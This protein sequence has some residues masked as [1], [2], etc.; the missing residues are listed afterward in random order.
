MMIDETEQVPGLIDADDQSSNIEFILSVVAEAGTDALTPEE[1]ATYQEY[2]DEQSL[3]EGNEGGHYENLADKISET[4]LS[5]L[6][7][8]VINWVTWDEES[9]QDWEI[10][11]AKGIRMLGVSDKNLTKE[12][13]K[14]CSQVVH[15]L[16]AEAIM[17]FHSRAI[18]EIWPPEGPV[19]TQVLGDLSDEITA[20]AERVQDYLNYLYTTQMPDGFEEVDQML[21]RL[22]LSGSCFKKHFYDPVEESIRSVFVE[23]SDF[24]VPYSATGLRTASR[25]TY[26]VRE[27]HNEVLKKIKI[28]YYRD[29]YVAKDNNESLDYPLVREEIDSS[30]GKTPTSAEDHQRHTMLEMYLDYAFESIDDS[31]DEHEMKGGKVSY[32]YQVIIDRDTSTVMRVQRNWKPDDPKKKKRIYFTHY[33]FMPGLGF[34]GYGLLHL[35]GGLAGAATG[36]LQA[37]M[38]SA[39][40][41]NMQGGFR[42]RDSRIQGGDLA[43]SP[44]EWREVDSSYEELQKAFFK[45]PY[46]EPSA[47][48]F[49]VMQYLDERGQRFVGTTESMVGEANNS[50]PVGTTL[51]LIEQGS[52]TFTSIHKR[53]HEACTKEYRFVAELCAEYL[54]E[55]GYPY[56]MPGASKQIMVSDFDDRVDVIPVSDPNIISSTQRMVQGQAILDL[57]TKNPFIINQRKAVEN[58][59]K[60]MRIPKHEEFLNPDQPPPPSPDEMLA[61]AQVEKLAAETTDIGIKSMYSAI[62]AGQIIATVPGV[63]PIADAIFA[64]AGGVDKNGPPIAPS[65]EQPMQQMPMPTNTNPMN[66]AVPQSPEIGVNAGIETMRN[67]G[68]M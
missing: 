23:P 32:P 65:P 34:Y 13:F 14:G 52:K 10:R 53:I 18:A 5:K 9:R 27:S 39:A 56:L 4:E 1:L 29:V 63:A 67:D 30:E 54:P 66:P 3:G 28:G 61:K 57:A 58:M 37:F 44:G 2:L 35:I 60:V 8:E 64:S 49:N 31:K 16:L 59:L 11:E 47:A 46:N 25:F 7:S 21:F 26:R 50:A 68:V 62:Q 48:V 38:D 55:E 20:Q 42:T 19:K 51:A 40:F 41:S 17:Q 12:R 33:K 6:A 24:I 45:V 36:M 15:P 43:L 22:P